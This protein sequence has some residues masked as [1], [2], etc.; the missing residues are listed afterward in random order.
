MPRAK[1]YRNPPRHTCPYPGCSRA[2]TKTYSLNNHQTR[3][4]NGLHPRTRLR[5]KKAKGNLLPS[6][7]APPPRSTQVPWDPFSNR[8]EF[9]TVYFLFKKEQMSGPRINELLQLWAASL[10]K[11]NDEPPFT[12][13]EDLYETLDAIPQGD[14]PWHSF[15]ASYTGPRPTGR[16]TPAWMLR[17]YTIWHRNPRTVVHNMF[18]NGDLDGEIDYTPYQ[19][20]LA[21]G[22]RDWKNVMSANWAWRQADE[23]AATCGDRVDGATFVPIILGSDKTT[24]SV[25]TGQNDFYP[26]YLSTGNPHNN[27]RRAHRQTVILIT[28]LAIPKSGRKDDDSEEFRSFRR[29]LFHSS[30]AHIL[31]PLLPGMTTPDI[32]Q[33]PDGHFRRLIYGLGPYIADYPEQV[34]LSCIVSGWC[35]RCRAKGAEMEDIGESRCKEHTEA[36]VRRFVDDPGGLWD[37]YG[38]IADAI[39]FTN[40]FPRADITQL[41]APD[42]LHQVI[43]GTFKDHLVAWIE[44]YLELTHGSARAKEIMDDIDRRIAASP[45]FPQLRRFPDGRRFKQWTGADSKALMRVILPAL[46]GHVPSEII[47]CVRSFLD[48]CYLLRLD[49]HSEDTLD[50]ID[51]ALTEFRQHR[52]FF[53]ESGVRPTGFSQPREHALLHY[54]E[55]IEEF[56]SPNGL[57]SS[58]TENRHITAVKEPWR[59]SSRHEALGQ[60]LLTNQRLDKLAAARTHFAEHGMLQTHYPRYAPALGGHIG[61]PDLLGCIRQFLYQQT[62][63]DD[64]RPLSEVPLDEYPSF[65]GRLRVY[66]SAVA[67]FHAPSDRSGIN[68]MACERIRATPSWRGGPARYDCVFV[69]TNAMLPGMRGLDIGRVRLLFSFVHSSKTYPCALVEWFTTVGDSPDT[70]TGMW[71]VEPEYEEGDRAISVIHLDSVIR[72][73][74]LLPFF[75][76]NFLPTDFHFSYSLDSFRAFFV[77]KYIDYHAN[78]IAF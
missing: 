12:S 15:S 26:L 73:A 17:E 60:M 14:A 56:G 22:Q 40:D 21:N 27:V 3:M 77:N 4:H 65:H 20:F 25:A 38:I 36:L 31:S 49:S 33:C 55:L 30:L 54:R 75:G 62:N 68:E 34:L 53:R 7:A 42:L 74:H 5:K 70:D 16:D 24:V 48:L 18:H 66:H 29:Q 61:F 64:I 52:E 23:I 41:L 51:V 44:Q 59:C 2:F 6:G 46:V 35:P 13:M 32:C 45:H 10:L 9:D 76:P 58:I 11:H 37:S 57:C 78:T 8:L 47:Q 28:F 19:D 72:N 50:Q 63:P 39:P 1:K 69:E 71:L 43:K 67:T